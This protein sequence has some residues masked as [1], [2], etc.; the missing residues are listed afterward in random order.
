[1]T[2]YGKARLRTLLICGGLLA[3]GAILGTAGIASAQSEDCSPAD[4][5]NFV[6]GLANLEKLIKI[7]GT[8]LGIGSALNGGPMERPPFYFFDFK[9]EEATAVKPENFKIAQESKN[10]PDCPAP[11]FGK[12]ISLGVD[13]AEVNGRE[14]LYVVNHGGRFSV[15]IF[16]MERGEG[17][18]KLT[19]IGCI[20]TPN[21]HFWPDDVAVLRDGGM[22]VTSLFDPTDSDFTNKLSAGEPHGALGEWHPDRGWTMLAEGQLSG[23]NGVIVTPDESKIIVADWGGKNIARIDR[24]SGEI[25]RAELGFLVDNVSWTEDGSAI[26][27]V[28]SSGTVKDGFGCFAT[29]VANCKLPFQGVIVDPETMEAKELFPPQTLGAMGGG[30]GATQDGDHLWITSWRADRIAK[31]PFK[32]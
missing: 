1:M 30:S 12:F 14:L 16:E 8:R 2:N 29:E 22:I 26:L 3:A 15:E 6:C 19:W 28:G 23:P 17:L 25:K 24:E 4:G 27:G 13:I 18:P 9:T 31:V 5:A 21:E 11:D 10:Y 32:N 20:T 7:D